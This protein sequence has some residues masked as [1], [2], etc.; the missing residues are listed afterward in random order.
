VLVWNLA[1]RAV[2]ATVPQPRPVTSV[3]WVGA[4]QVAASDAN[5]TIA[6][7]SLPSP[8]LATGSSPASVAYS[9]G[10]KTIAAALSGICG[11]LGQAL[12]PA[13]WA[14]YAPGVPYRAPC[15]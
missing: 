2:T 11:N 8:V 12:T 10:G 3:A 13:E 15:P 1:R 14:S 7:V 4:D 5:G 6:L 9:P